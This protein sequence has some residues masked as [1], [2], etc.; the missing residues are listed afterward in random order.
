MPTENAHQR[1]LA[2]LP[3]SWSICDLRALGSIVGG[4]TP[5]RAISRFWNGNIPWV[6]PGEMTALVGTKF[7]NDTRERITRAGYESCGT[8][9]LPPGS[10]LITTRATLGLVA[11]AGCEVSTNQGFKSVVFCRDNYPDFY[12]HLFHRLK[13]EM[14]RLASGTTF[15]EISAGDFGR[16]TIPVPP[17][18]EQR[19]IAAVL[20]TIDDAI[21]KTEQ[22]IAKLQQVKQGLLHDL[23]TRGIDDNGELRDLERHLEQFQ[24]SP[25]GRIPK[26]WEVVRLRDEIRIEHGFAFPGTGFVDEPRGPVLLTPGN[27]HRDG[28]LYFERS[29]TKHFIGSVPVGYVLRAGDIVTVMTDLSP[30]TLILGRTE[31]VGTERTLL[32]N[33]RI[34]KVVPLRVGRWT[35]NL[36]AMAMSQPPIRGRVVREA[37][38]TTV[39][40]TSPD[41]ILACCIAR[42]GMA[43]QEVILQ[44]MAAEMVREAIE[45]ETHRRL[46]ALRAGLSEDLLTGRVRTTSLPGF[47]A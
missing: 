5:S 36:L 8:R 21:Q 11:L 4:S 19:A 1:Y 34:G 20:D 39:R 16:I 17:P 32:H 41:R 43:E 38:G 25:L 45:L 14:E 10:L 35:N 6:T 46:V 23:L 42:P 44:V 33:Q 28:G 3:N 27:F 15:L 9:L 18:S 47:S 37:T 24:D 31:V 12:F 29:N 26:G 30:R 13:P 2:E 7:L 22:I 40:H